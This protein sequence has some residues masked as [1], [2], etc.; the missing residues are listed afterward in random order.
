MFFP[1]YQNLSTIEM[2]AKISQLENLGKP[3]QDF[4]YA[5]I[6]DWQGSDRRKEMLTAQ[7]YYEN[8]ND[9]KDRKRYYIDRKGIQKEAENVSNSKLSHPFMRRLTNQKVNYLLAK[10]PTFK[11]TTNNNEFIEELEK[12]LDNNFFRMLKNVGKDAI[13]KGIA[14]L[15]VY[16]NE[17]G[18]LS[19]KRIPSEEIVPFWADAE[20]TKLNAVIRVY[21]ILELGK[22]AE[23]KEVYKVEYHT[24]NGVW[25]YIMGEKGLKPDPN[26]G[27]MGYGHFVVSKEQ[28]DEN[29]KEVLDEQ[30]NPVSTEVEA[31]WE[32]IPF[33]PFKYN[34]DE[35]S[36]LS[37]VKTQIDDYD[38]NTSDTSNNLQDVPNSIKV[39]RNYDGSDKGE[40]VQ[41][42]AT[43]RTAFVSGDGDMT[44]LNTPLD[45]TAVDSHL[46]RLRRDIFEGGCGVDTQDEALGTASGVALKFRYSGLDIDMNDMGNEFKASLEQLI[47]FIKVDMLGKGIGDFME[48]KF[49]IVFNKNII[50]N[51]AEIIN[52]AKQSVGM[53]SDE[54]IVAHHPWVEDVSAE[55]DKLEEQRQKSLENQLEEIETLGG[56][57]MGFGTNNPAKAPTPKKKE[58]KGGDK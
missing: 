46:N 10:D 16:Y 32:R 44:A 52:M 25:Y 1:D 12:Y 14:W 38:I 36:L 8:K 40:F 19:F 49:N 22:D 17:E 42:L 41:N 47:W 29:G 9:I 6:T 56:A 51:E 26:K 7:D 15:Q 4:I 23:K 3:E 28:T 37:L 20:H 35:I 55:M 34:S 13:N 45:I 43:F 27:D 57:D 11:S 2:Q 30:G 58:S 24:V 33:I 21:S 54:T 53:I 50:V 31:T 39:V 18:A 48:E 5:H